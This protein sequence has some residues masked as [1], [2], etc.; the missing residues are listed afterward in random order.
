M[1]TV[2]PGRLAVEIASG[3]GA[4][5]AGG[6]QHVEPPFPPDGVLPEDEEEPLEP[7][8][9][10]VELSLAFVWDAFA[11]E[12]PMSQQS[13]AHSAAAKTIWEFEV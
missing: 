10:P 3:T 9:E 6:L 7:E 5:A 2:P 1:P 4:T 8:G 12:H 13:E 11:G